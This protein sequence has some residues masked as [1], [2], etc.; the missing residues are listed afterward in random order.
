MKTKLVRLFLQP[1]L[2][3]CNCT[4][5]ATFRENYAHRILSI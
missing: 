2:Q 3:F 4:S 5:Q 1:L